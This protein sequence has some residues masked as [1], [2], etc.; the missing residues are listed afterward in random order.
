MHHSLL[1]NLIVFLLS[2]T[3]SI[4][5]ALS[6]S[7]SNQSI[8][9]QL[10]KGLNEK[11]YTLIKSLF[12]KQSFEQFNKQYI[13]F[14][15]KYKDSKWSFQTKNNFS[16]KNYLDVKIS[17]TRTIGGLNYKLNSEQNIEIETY[18]N[19][20][21]NYKVLEEESVLNSINTPLIIKINSPEEVLTGQKYEINLI[22]ENPLDNSLLASGMITLHNKNSNISQEYFH[23]RPNQSGGVFKYVQ[24]PLKPGFQTISAIITHPK[25]IYSI[26]KKIK[27]GL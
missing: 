17:S 22:I 7:I 10:E 27:V 26:T 25:G 13:D 19:K 11:N 16:S 21:K 5:S 12:S 2:C 15:K 18:N 14:T 23:I 24:A 4:N 3:T 20:I 8:I 9:N 6:K 1:I